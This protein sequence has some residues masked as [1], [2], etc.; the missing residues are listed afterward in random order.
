MTENDF[1]KYSL[2]VYGNPR[3]AKACLALQDNHQA[4]VNLLLF[5]AWIARRHNRLVDQTI[6]ALS[7]DCM[8]EIDNDIVLPLRS[9]RN[10]IDKRTAGPEL[11]DLRQKILTL[12]LEAEKLVQDRLYALS[13]EIIAQCALSSLPVQ[14]IARRN[15][16]TYGNF[17]DRCFPGDAVD[18]LSSLA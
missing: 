18:S 15:L 11:M 4:N 8:S 5:F 3:V 1:W 9:A 16:E 6:C 13:P 12:E 17:L 10:A 2:E 7:T 14:E